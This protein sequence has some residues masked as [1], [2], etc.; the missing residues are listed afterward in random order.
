M[1][2]SL[3]LRASSISPPRPSDELG[4]AA[5]D[6]DDEDPLVEDGHRLEHTEVDEAGL[7]D[8]GDHLDVHPGFV[9]GPLRGTR[10]GSSASRTA[11]V[12]TAWTSASGGVGDPA[13]AGEGGD[14]AVDG[15][16]RQ[17]LHVA[18]ARPEPHDLLLAV[19]DLEAVVARRAGDDEVE[20]VGPEV[21]GGDGRSRF[22]RR[23]HPRDATGP[24]VRW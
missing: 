24:N 14:A 15:L 23:A 17:L 19:E 18:R 3:R 6:V 9:A 16:G 10:R 21:D 20:A 7:L 5:A 1:A 12:A 2:P 8:A 13:E 4:R 22:V 11:L